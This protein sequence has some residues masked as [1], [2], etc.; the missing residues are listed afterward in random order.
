MTLAQRNTPW[1]MAGAMIAPLAI[2]TALR[3]FV[4]GA[5]VAP[6]DAAASATAPMLEPEAPSAPLGAPSPAHARA[7][8]ALLAMRRDPVALSPLDHPEAPIDAPVDA[9]HTPA[10][11][12]GDAQR[13]ARS[14]VADL[15]LSSI[16]RSSRTDLAGINGRIYRVGQEVRPGWTVQSIDADASRV[17]LK[18]PEQQTFTLTRQR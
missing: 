9:H 1:L 8:E 4:G 2:V 14:P 6:A 13:P 16:M 11:T 7:L 10:P 15:T 17:V 12:P 18:G 5:G 3:T